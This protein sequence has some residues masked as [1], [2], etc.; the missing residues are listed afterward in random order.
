MERREVGLMYFVDQRKWHQSERRVRREMKQK[1]DE[2]V[3][4]NGEEKDGG[5]GAKMM[6][7]EGQLNQERN[8]KNPLI[9]RCE[10]KCW[11]KK[12]LNESYYTEISIV[13]L[14]SSKIA[15]NL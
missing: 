3:E 7:N 1:L 15:G 4:A 14:S 2:N 13:I 5:G 12:N 9:H 8:Q 6:T 10:K 11:K